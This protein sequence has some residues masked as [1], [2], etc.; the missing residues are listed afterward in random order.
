LR[1]EYCYLICALKRSSFSVLSVE[2]KNQEGKAQSGLI[3]QEATTVITTMLLGMRVFTR[4][5]RISKCPHLKS[6][7]LILWSK[8]IARN[9]C[10]IQNI[11]KESSFNGLHM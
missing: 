8:V 1:E 4:P 5:P 11:D 10:Q 9:R 3:Y 7:E 6:A 2:S